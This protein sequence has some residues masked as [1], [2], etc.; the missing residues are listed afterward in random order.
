[1]NNFRLDKGLL[2]NERILAKNKNLL[3]NNFPSYILPTNKKN[4]KSKSDCP[5]TPCEEDNTDSSYNFKSNQK[6][7]NTDSNFE[8][9]YKN[10]KNVTG[11]FYRNERNNFKQLEY[12]P[13]REQ[14]KKGLSSEF[15]ST[16]LSGLKRHFEKHFKGEDFLK[17]DN[18]EKGIK[19]LVE[20]SKRLFKNYNISDTFWTQPEVENDL[21]DIIVDI[22][23]E[24]IQKRETKEYKEKENKRIEKIDKKEKGLKSIINQSLMVKLKVAIKES[25]WESDNFEFYS[26]K[27]VIEHLIIIAKKVFTKEYSLRD[28]FWNDKFVIQDLL[29]LLEECRELRKIFFANNP[30]VKKEYTKQ[31]D[32][33]N[34]AYQSM[35]LS[36]FEY[37]IENG[38]TDSSDHNILETIERIEPVAQSGRSNGFWDRSIDDLRILFY[39]AK[40]IHTEKSSNYKSDILDNSLIDLITDRLS[41]ELK[42]GNIDPSKEYIVEKFKILFPLLGENKTESFWKTNIDTFIEIF[43]R[44]RKKSKAIYLENPE[45]SD[46]TNSSLAVIDKD[47]KIKSVDNSTKLT[48]S[49]KAYLIDQLKFLIAK[50]DFKLNNLGLI[51]EAKNILLK[52]SYFIIGKIGDLERNNSKELQECFELAFANYTHESVSSESLSSKDLFSLILSKYNNQPSL[53]VRDSNSVINQAYSTPSPLALLLSMY[54]EINRDDDAIENIYEP[55]GGNGLLLSPFI[56]HL[57]HRTEIHYNELDEARFHRFKQFFTARK[58]IKY[59]NENAINYNPGAKFDLIVSNPPFGDYS[60]KIAVDTNYTINSLDHAITIHTAKFLKPDG[61]Y[62]V[63]LGGHTLENDYKWGGYRLRNSQFYN[64]IYSNY[65]VLKHID[66][67]GDLYRK[68]GT[69]FDIQILIFQNTKPVYTRVPVEYSTDGNGIAKINTWTELYDHLIEGK[70]NGYKQKTE[71]DTK[72]TI[73]TPTQNTGMETIRISSNAGSTGESRGKIGSNTPTGTK[74]QRRRYTPEYSPIPDSRSGADFSKEESSSE[75]SRRDRKPRGDNSISTRD[76]QLGNG[77]Y[78][79]N[80]SAPPILDARQEERMSGEPTPVFDENKMKILSEFFEKFGK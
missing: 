15:G 44:A 76:N 67:N 39:Q 30:L 13:Q 28:E 34:H 41:I 40:I 31:T 60:P 48:M 19:K 55:C 23:E 10:E 46:H 59:T 77:S 35:V 50:K 26:E 5:P 58:T 33:F 16:L 56:A 80:R 12:N 17:F 24:R 63:I 9:I 79:R 73:N 47:T 14:K 54:I 52:S 27:S 49:G 7:Y 18:R 36:K 68:Q 25:I 22:R 72:T 65:T 53:S 51:A 21:W 78:T 42:N 11:N 8:P 37:E 74:R 70:N 4:R 6:K 43:E 66:V 71:R 64:Y 61:I 29:E 20:L 2:S 57:N 75:N 38:N 62:V 32:Y 1:M 45:K 69:S 3:I